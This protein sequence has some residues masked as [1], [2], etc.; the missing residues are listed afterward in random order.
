VH[1]DGVWFVTR[2]KTNSCYEVV[3][4]SPASGPILADQIIRLNSP[5][6]QACYPDRLRRVHYQDPE[7]GKEYVFLTNRLDLAALQV[8]ELYRCR[9]QVELFSKWIKQN[10]KI[11]TCYGTSQNAVLI[12]IWTALISYLL[13]LWLKFRSKVEWGLLE[14][15]RLAQTMLLERCDLWALLCPKPPDPRHPPCYSTSVP[16]TNGG[17]HCLS[18]S[19]LG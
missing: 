2:L 15:S 4:A 13:L 17:S 16:D 12:Q 18:A 8:A 14:L 9:W 3:Q 19:L 10:L 6:G 5:R 1:Q 11:K 7:T